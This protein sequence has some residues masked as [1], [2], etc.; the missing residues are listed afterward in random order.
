M[1]EPSSRRD[2]LRLD[3]PL[4]IT[5]YALR[6]ILRSHTDQ[7][8]EGPQRQIELGK[9]KNEGKLGVLAHGGEAVL[10]KVRIGRPLERHSTSRLER[11]DAKPTVG[12]PTLVYAN[13]SPDPADPDRALSDRLETLNFG[14]PTWIIPEEVLHHESEN[15]CGREADQGLGLGLYHVRYRPRCAWL[16]R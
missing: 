12:A 3:E 5:G 16:P 15:L 13:L 4:Q 9:L 8:F 1:T 10:D 7:F 2:K 14:R 11:D 6:A